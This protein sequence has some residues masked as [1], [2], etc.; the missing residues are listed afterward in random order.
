MVAETFLPPVRWLR[1]Y[2]T[3]DLMADLVAGLI[4]SVLLVPQAM[5]Y[6]TLAGLPP[7][8]GLYTAILPPIVYACLGT[9]SCTSVG[10]VAL[11][12]LLV[13]DAIAGAE[14]PAGIAASIIAVEVGLLL[15]PLGILRLGRLVN[16]ISDPALL[17][18]TAAAAVLI[19]LSQIPPLL[20]IDAERGGDALTMVQ[21]IHMAIGEASAMTFAV[22]AGGLLL[23]LFSEKF[24]GA[25]LWKLGVRPPIRGALL[26][27]T[28]LL[29]LVVSAALVSW[30]SLDV[31]TVPQPPS[32]LP[33]AGFPPFD[34]AAWSAML[35]SAAII[36]IVIF[37]TGTAISK[38]LA[39]RQRKSLNTSQEAIA[40]GAAGIASAVTGGYA[41]G[42]SFSRS[43]LLHDS[44]GRSPLASAIGAAIVLLVALFFAAP[45]AYLPKAALAALVIS[46]VF[47]LIKP[48]E[49]LAIW[50]HSRTEGGVIALT[51]MAT[52][53][54][55]VQWGLATG[56]AAGI[57]AFLWFSSLPRV[58]RLGETGGDTV[59]FRSVD[60]EGVEVNSMPVLVIRIDRSLY[61]GNVGHCEDQL[62]ALLSRHPDAECLLI[63][64]RGVN[65]I[66][67]SGIAMLQRLVNDVEEKQLRVGFAELRAPLQE[68][69]DDDR[70]LCP[71]PRY[72]DVAEGVRKM[73]ESC[74]A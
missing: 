12:S 62:L 20:G 16:F 2:S 23:L 49:M 40:L 29:M 34:V 47:G 39:G 54:L 32:G 6:A 37:V 18:F 5:A 26:K 72:A 14:M 3:S 30:F 28:P 42:V 71:C 45:L 41:P 48:K 69:F 67:A 1:E 66:D 7:E 55:G 19:A 64:M 24:G 22:G 35:P 17:G 44:G 46:A 27:S 51:I 56:A 25:A 60:R 59:H 13:A 9:S 58:T 43:A 8:I 11:P 68:D 21:N 53:C 50:R 70:V 31:E 10:P 65:E 74:G 36:A 73:R 63:D 4:L 33:K 61:F 52:L 57:I 38:S 15:L